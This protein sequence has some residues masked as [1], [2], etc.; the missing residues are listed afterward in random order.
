M[1]K[2]SILTLIA[3]PLALPAPALAGKCVTP[4]LK[5]ELSKDMAIDW[6]RFGS[7]DPATSSDVYPTIEGRLTLHATD[8]F[9][10]TGN[11]VTEPVTDLA[12]G[13]SRVFGDV[14][15]YAD[16][17][18]A[19][20]VLGD[21]T[22]TAGKIHP[23][24][25]LAWDVTPGLHGTDVAET[26]ELTERLG[27]EVAYA[28]HGGALEYTIRA[29]AFTADRTLLSDS[30]FTRRGRLALSDGG[31]GNTDGVSSV[32]VALD[33]C[34][35]T[36]P[37]GC[38]EWGDWGFH[39]GVRTQQ[40]GQAQLDEDGNVLPAGDETGAV[41]A[42]FRSFDVGEDSKLTLF[43]EAAHFW[44]F[45]G[46]TDNADFLTASVALTSGDVTYSLAFGH[47]T[48]R[49]LD[50]TDIKTDLL[51]VSVDYTVPDFT[52][53]GEEWTIGAGYSLTRDDGQDA[54]TFGLHVAAAIDGT[55]PLG[56]SRNA[57]P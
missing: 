9:I 15:T 30:A 44:N 23:A 51:D 40:A 57:A 49:T 29:S 32:A 28:F 36:S 43:G 45:N 34:S 38:I 11:F 39:L 33:G 17:L 16:E 41:A 31:A 25:G 26:Y 42:I 19:K 53:A 27:G 24:F 4:C 13:D 54:Q 35:G 10:M 21:W 3:G 5:Y 48:L 37:E 50:G 7:P 22:L 52:L 18:N 12:P 8:W 56:G 47:E 20:L 14:G 6:T 55:V 1:L 2:R 46:S